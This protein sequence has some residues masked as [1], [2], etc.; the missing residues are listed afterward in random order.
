MILRENEKMGIKKYVIKVFLISVLLLQFLYFSKPDRGGIQTC[1]K[2]FGLRGLD[3]IA[4]KHRP[5]W[6]WDL[7]ESRKY[8]FEITPEEFSKLRSLLALSGYSEWTEKGLTFGSVDIGW[9]SDDKF[10][11]VEK[12]MSG[13]LFYWSYSR[14]ENLVYAISWRN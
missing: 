10:I 13:M 12:R 1:S 3:S 7:F 4:M 2:T 5:F 11:V 8:R 9:N 6:S 14:E